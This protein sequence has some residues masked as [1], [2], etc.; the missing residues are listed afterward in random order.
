MTL[1]FLC[2]CIC[3]G[4]SQIII[5]T[6]MIASTKWE[7]KNTSSKNQYE[8]TKDRLIW[9]HRNGKTVSYPYYLCSTIPTSFDFSKVGKGTK[10]HIYVEYNEKLKSFTCYTI[11]SF[12]LIKGE[13]IH[14]LITKDII[15]NSDTF[16]FKQVK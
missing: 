14:K 11:I 4:M 7:L 6:S 10:G 9:H 2:I 12:D 15:G 1:I 5:S 13:M 8:F 16:S 3:K